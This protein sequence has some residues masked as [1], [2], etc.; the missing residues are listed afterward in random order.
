M[1]LCPHL[2]LTEALTSLEHVNK[3]NTQNALL[4]TTQ[5]IAGSNTALPD[6]NHSRTIARTHSNGRLKERS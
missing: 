6:D 4:N 2:S 3:I 1:M 5:I